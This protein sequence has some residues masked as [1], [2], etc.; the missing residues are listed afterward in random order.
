MDLKLVVLCAML[1]M[2]LGASEAVNK[3]LA[4][5]GSPLKRNALSVATGNDTQKCDYLQLAK[6]YTSC[7]MPFYADFIS[8]ALLSSPSS[9]SPLT[10]F[11]ACLRNKYIGHL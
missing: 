2:D 5:K 1:F 7:S 3:N 6:T 10:A 9:C 4:T 11:Q 8:N